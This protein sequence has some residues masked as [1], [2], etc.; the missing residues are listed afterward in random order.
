MAKAISD[1]ELQLKK[2]ARRRLVGAIALVLLIVVF[3]PMVLDNEP[4]PLNQDVAITIPPIPKP[5][6]I[7]QESCAHSNRPRGATPRDGPARGTDRGTVPSRRPIHRRTIRSSPNQAGRQAEEKHD[8]KSAATGRTGSEESFVVQ[9]GAFSNAA[10]AKSLQ[11][12]LQDN[13]FKAYTDTVKNAGGNRVR[14]RVGP[15]PSREAAEK[16][17]D[18]LKAMRLVI[19]ESA[20]VRRPKAPSHSMPNPFLKS[21][22]R[23]QPVF[24][25]GRAAAND[26]IRPGRDSGGCNLDWVQHLARFGQGSALPSVMGRGVL[27]GEAVCRC[28]RRLVALFMEPSGVAY[29]DR[30]RRCHAGELAGPESGVCVGR[31]SGKVAGLTAS[32]RMLGAVFR[33]GARIA[34]CRNSGASRRHDFGAP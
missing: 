3:L 22:P 16:A 1:E 33:F 26:G 10:N 4:K 17:R 29:R 18:R 8:L 5:E 28:R 24:K 30:I 9:L 15:Y 31:A 13:K 21:P 23:P 32:D 7:P 19:G 12:K 34:D 27:A 2:R 6:S 25:P 14:V 20:V 11:K